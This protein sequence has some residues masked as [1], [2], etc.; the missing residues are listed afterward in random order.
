M[1]GFLQLNDHRSPGESNEV[2]QN[3]PWVVY[4]ISVDGDEENPFYIG[5]TT[6]MVRRA[7]DHNRRD[8]AC[9]EVAR[10]YDAQGIHCSLVPVAY[11]ATK[12]QARACESLLIAFRTRLVNRDVSNHVNATLYRYGEFHAW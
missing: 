5:M 11:F 2:A 10:G 1:T 6:D 3:L 8:S 7:S 4:A 12:E 9:Y